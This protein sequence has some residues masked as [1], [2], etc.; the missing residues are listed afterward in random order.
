MRGFT[1]L[2]EMMYGGGK[3]IHNQ[4]GPRRA[5]ILDFQDFL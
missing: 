4:G 2:A 1:V 5:A 3:K